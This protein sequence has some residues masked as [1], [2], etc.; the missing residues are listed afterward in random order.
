LDKLT[1][2]MDKNVLSRE[3]GAGTSNAT[4]PDTVKRPR[5]KAKVK[6]SNSRRTGMQLF[7]LG[8]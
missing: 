6:L 4:N 1:E 8:F 5:V 2:A 3:E 7:F